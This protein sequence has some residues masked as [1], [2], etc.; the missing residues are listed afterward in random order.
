MA[1]LKKFK[2]NNE[3]KLSMLGPEIYRELRI[4]EGYRPAKRSPTKVRPATLRMAKDLR[5]TD[6]GEEPA[7]G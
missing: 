5:A 4:G 7:K 3:P 6:W 2:A 1:K